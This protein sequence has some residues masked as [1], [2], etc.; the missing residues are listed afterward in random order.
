MMEELKGKTAASLEAMQIDIGNRAED[1]YID[2][3]RQLN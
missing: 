1:K 2:L 3:V